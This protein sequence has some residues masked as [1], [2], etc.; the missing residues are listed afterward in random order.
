MLIKSELPE[1]IYNVLAE[2]A[3][4]LLYFAKLSRCVSR[5]ISSAAAMHFNEQ[6]AGT[7]LC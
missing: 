3:G 1:S 4:V 2:Q 7:P 5:L 6:R